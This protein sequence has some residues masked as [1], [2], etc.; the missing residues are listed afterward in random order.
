MLNSLAELIALA[1]HYANIEVDDL[2]YVLKH[3]DQQ[4]IGIVAT[5]WHPSGE[6]Q[7]RD[8]IP[9][10]V[11]G[12][13]FA[14]LNKQPLDGTAARNLERLTHCPGPVKIVTVS[15]VLDVP[16]TSGLRTQR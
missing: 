9:L 13:G 14:V 6:F 1:R 4:H 11:V 5:V 7:G 10:L 2:V 8:D 3:G 15:D 16:V 12:V